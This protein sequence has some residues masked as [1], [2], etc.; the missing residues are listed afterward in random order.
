MLDFYHL[1][2]EIASSSV[3]DGENVGAEVNDVTHYKIHS[4]WQSG[5]GSVNQMQE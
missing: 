1:I 4:K 3:F 2:Q 5:S